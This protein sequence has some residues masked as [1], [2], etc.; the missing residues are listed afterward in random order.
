MVLQSLN[1][2]EHHNVHPHR[3]LQSIIPLCVRLRFRL[4]FVFT[5]PLQPV[6]MAYRVANE[7]QHYACQDAAGRAYGMKFTTAMAVDR[8]ERDFLPIFRTIT[9]EQWQITQ[10]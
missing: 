8:R 6:T 2:R 3:L 7:R 5:I 9:I 4:S 10:A 1:N